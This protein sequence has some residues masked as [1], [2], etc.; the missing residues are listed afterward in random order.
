ME[1]ASTQCV[2]TRETVSVC[3]CHLVK[4]PQAGG[5]MNTVHGAAISAVGVT[6]SAESSWLG[7][8]PG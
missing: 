8:C 7:Q 2:S 1:E 4:A 3:V 6:V 5:A